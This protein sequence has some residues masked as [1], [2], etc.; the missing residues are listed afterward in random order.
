LLQPR[1]CAEEQ[2]RHCVAFHRRGSASTFPL[3]WL[4][5]IWA[6][7]VVHHR[8]LQRFRDCATF[9]LNVDF[10]IVLTFLICTGLKVTLDDLIA[11][12]GRASDCSQFWTWCYRAS[13]PIRLVKSSS[14]RNVSRCFV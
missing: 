2:P 1:C 4:G 13:N 9:T 7:S 3:A 5:T 11:H 6:D 14:S 10:K 12:A 8:G